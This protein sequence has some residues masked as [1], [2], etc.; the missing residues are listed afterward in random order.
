MLVEIDG[1][2]HIIHKRKQPDGMSE[3]ITVAELKSMIEK[4]R[5]RGCV[6]LLKDN[7]LWEPIIETIKFLVHFGIVM[8]L[9][10][11]GAW[12]FMQLEEPEPESKLKLSLSHF[13]NTTW[14]NTTNVM[15]SDSPF[16]WTKVQQKY[17]VNVSDNLRY[18]FIADVKEMILKRQQYRDMVARRAELE[19][20]E[21]VWMKWFYFT[22]ITTT[23]I[24]YGDIFP[25]TSYGQLFYIGFS[26]IGISTM[27]TLLK[28]CG[29]ILSL[30]NKKMYG[31]V[32][33]YLCGRGGGCIG[34]EALSLLTMIMFF[35]S[36]MAGEL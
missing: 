2:L 19:D 1:V 6:Q 24:G 18:S 28:A 5:K 9:L 10:F 33:R 29:E 17:K 26:I 36:F 4:Q 15:H 20:R 8:G 7:G 13:S 22:V 30:C 25:K 16:L 35:I 11:C 27:M 21:F 34:Q 23:T 3:M 31:L 14:P 12:V 32:N